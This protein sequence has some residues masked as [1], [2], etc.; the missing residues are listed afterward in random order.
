MAGKK[1]K[2]AAKAGKADGSCCYD[3]S[4]SD[5]RHK[6][7]IWIMLLLGLIGFLM[8]LKFFDFGAYNVFFQYTWS[9]VI[10]AMAMTKLLGIKM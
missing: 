4:C 2:K 10:L 5:D 7:E 1:M 8:A 3:S 9:L 6:L